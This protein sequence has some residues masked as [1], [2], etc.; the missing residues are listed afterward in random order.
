MKKRKKI[1]LLARKA[2]AVLLSIFLI[3]SSLTPAFANTGSDVNQYCDYVKLVDIDGK[4]V[5]GKLQSAYYD[6]DNKSFFYL[7]LSDQYDANKTAKFQLEE[8]WKVAY[9]DYYG[10]EW[11]DEITSGYSIALSKAYDIDYDTLASNSFWPTSKYK[12][13]DGYTYKYIIC[14]PYDSD[15]NSP[16]CFYFVFKT[17]K[18]LEE[19]KTL[20]KERIAAAPSEETDTQYYHSD[21]R[22][23]GKNK[24]EKGFWADMRA[25]VERAKKVRDSKRATKDEIARAEATLDLNNPDST[26]SKAIAKLIPKTRINPTKLYESLTKTYIWGIGDKVYSSTWYDGANAYLNVKEENATPISWKPYAE[27][28]E[29]GK[30]FYKTMYDADGTPTAANNQAAMTTCTAKNDAIEAARNRLVQKDDYNSAYQTFT[31]RMGEAVGLLNQYGPAKFGSDEEGAYDSTK[32]PFTADSWAA[33]VDAYKTLKT[34]TQYKIKSSVAYPKGGSYE[35]YVAIKDFEKQ[36]NDFQKKLN[37][38]VSARDIEVEVSYVNNSAARYPQIKG[39]GTDIYYNAKLSLAS[40]S[41]T[42]HGILERTGISFDNEPTKY[43]IVQDGKE[44]SKNQIGINLMIFVDGECRG[45]YAYNDNNRGSDIPLQLHDGEKVSIVRIPSGFYVLEASSGYDSTAKYYELTRAI[46]KMGESIGQIS[47]DSIT[48]NIKVGDTVSIKT[49]AKGTYVTNHGQNLSAENLTLFV[50]GKSSDKSD[51][52]TVKDLK[53]TSAVTDK[54]GNA[55][56]VFREPGWYTIA[57]FDLQEE[58]PEFTDV[59]SAITKGSYPGAKAGAY[60]QVHVGPA[61]DEDAALAKWRKT[62]L[63]EAKALYETYHDEAILK[64]YGNY[65]FNTDADYEAFNAA[66]ETL[67]ANQEAEAIKSL[68]DLMDAY[69]RDLAAMNTHVAK[70]RDHKTLVQNV[71]TPLSYLPETAAEV[72]YVYKDLFQ[73]MKTAYEALNAYEVKELLSPAEQ[74]KIELLLKNTGD[75][76]VPAKTPI[77]ISAAEELKAA[78]GGHN[79]E[80]DTPDK[81]SPWQNHVY[82]T[83]PTGKE[84]RTYV[85]YG[86][87]TVGLEP[88]CKNMGAHPGDRVVIDR[89]MNQSD[90]TYW[91]MYSL[92]GTDWTPAKQTWKD[93]ADSV[94]MRAEFRMPQTD[95]LTVQLKG[96]SKTDYETLTAEIEKLTEAEREEGKSAIQAAYD[97]YDLTKYDVAGQAALKKALEDGLAAVAKAATKQNAA[98][99]RKVALAAMAAVA[100]AKDSGEETPVVKQPDYDSGKTI[101]KVYVTIENTKYAGGA[102]TGTIVSGQYDL[103]EKDSMMTCILKALQMGGYGWTGTGG[104]GQGYGITYISGIFED[105]NGNGKLDSGERSL[106]EF[107]GGKKS[108]WMGT[109]NDWFNNEGFAMFSVKN[110]KLENGDELHVMYTTDYGEDIGG[111]WNNGNT[112][113]AGLAISGGSLS[114]AFSAGQ[115]EYTLVISGDKANVRVTP[116]AANKNYQARIFLNRYNQDSA[117]YKRTET[118]SVKSGDVLYVGVGESGWPTMNTSSAGTKYTIKVVSGADAS[119]VKKMLAALKTIT[120]NNYKTEK[121]AV[122]AARSAYNA[123]TDKSAVTAAELKK[124]TDAEAQIKFYSEIDDA[125]AKLA[126][127]PKLSN[128]T[129]EQANAYRSQINAATAAYKKLSAE[130]KKFITKADVDNYN[131]LAAV[132]GVE[133]IAGAAEMPESP[134]STTGEKGSATTSAPTEVKVS[135]KTK[136]DGTKETVAEVK[137]DTA[138]HEEI[139]KQATENK[140]AE[141]VLE[142]AVSDT[143][144]ADSVQLS[145]E[146]SFVKNISDKTDAD[147]TVNTENGKVTL[148]QETIK[149]VL[150]EAKGATITLEVTKVSNPTEVQKKAAG[151]NG[152][153]LKLT[154][155]SGDKVISDFNKGKVKVVAEIV[156]KLLDKKVAAIHIAD[157]GKIEQLAGKVL[158]IGGKKYYEFTTPH[159]STFALVD[160]DE[161]GLEVAEEPTVDAKALTAKLTPVARSA[162]TAK[163]NVK[164][165]VSLDKQ[166]KAIVQELK[167]AGYTVKYRFYRS[168]KKAA[169]YKAAVT[170]KTSTYT[171]TSGKKGKKYYYKVQVRVYDANGKLAA[172]TAL[173]QCK[174]ASRIWTR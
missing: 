21:D 132:L 158:T 126:V 67:K 36:I 78:Y 124:L 129:K 150:A 120:Y 54:N 83:D 10:A 97:S 74:A 147:L 103:G 48:P 50:S 28:L 101:G 86:T 46:D 32:C 27:A 153:L 9:Y 42:I 105:K 165:T 79:E 117:R 154:I 155:K 19:D 60:M 109:Q 29:A 39:S 23:D 7:Y 134:I 44:Q 149:T 106:S 49:S 11:N 125:K 76:A 114:P 53:K 1:A 77:E 128:P 113:L 56:Y 148:D 135:E 41:T 90:S 98:D 40:G 12:F 25:V 68:K 71:K 99:A 115:K 85:E 5:R 127:L 173:K 34:A 139:I 110:G 168:T 61:N 24:S 4:D 123:L 171:N 167:D 88:S 174:Y 31:N 62:N 107:D 91:M 64:A 81:D 142:V 89:L 26:L 170:K 146:V 73:Q 33:Y 141:I 111:S 87:R 37:A 51:T 144:G 65:S 116:S 2:Y 166:D 8:N 82:N 159:F 121:T 47:I 119:A 130:Q 70:A 156:S 133:T 169:G 15:G 160:A 6:Q 145:L 18:I 161:L 72:T 55:E 52:L 136:A 57:L 140:S 22:F 59:Y 3:C 162:K 131:A 63:A 75:I 93:S 152:H 92:D 95:S 38:L 84:T 43:T 13:D 80:Y 100:A 112:S 143:K 102:L 164:V 58:T 66:Y 151:A 17:G 69:D 30:A 137:V 157:D 172:K 96:I 35:D 163:K 104:G 122:E 118:I 108:G 14:S 94:L 45:I 138:H 20:L 16:A